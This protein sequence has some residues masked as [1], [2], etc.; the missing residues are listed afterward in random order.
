M[1]KELTQPWI[2]FLMLGWLDSNGKLLLLGTSHSLIGSSFN[3]VTLPSRQMEWWVVCT[4]MWGKGGERATPATQ[5]W[6]SKSYFL[7]RYLGSPGW[8]T[9][10]P[11][12]H[13][14]VILIVPSSPTQLYHITSCAGRQSPGLQ[15]KNNQ[16]E[17]PMTWDVMA[18]QHLSNCRALANWLK[19]D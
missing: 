18:K 5:H 15:I 12:R 4:V 13:V 11:L 3:S 17:S 16:R 2:A 9:F 8:E 6:D 10:F 14:Q 1:T 19:W 7:C